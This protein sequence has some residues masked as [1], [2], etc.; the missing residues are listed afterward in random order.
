VPWRTEALAV[1]RIQIEPVSARTE[2][3]APLYRLRHWGAA[4]G[5][6]APL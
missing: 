4:S 2:G 1:G 5:P 3:A 6:R